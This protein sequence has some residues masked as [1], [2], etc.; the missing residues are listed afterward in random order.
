MTPFHLLMSK[1]EAALEENGHHQIHAGHSD[2]DF[3]AVG[4]SLIPPREVAPEPL[5]VP[6]APND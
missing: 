1:T 6:A 2:F 4:R 5:N 3:E